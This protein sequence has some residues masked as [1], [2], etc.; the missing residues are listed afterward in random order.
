MTRAMR[1]LAGA[2]CAMA[3]ILPAGAMTTQGWT[4]IELGTL[5]GPGSYGAAIS[6]NGTVVGCADVNGATA[7][8]FI[9]RDGVMRDLTTAS[10]GTS[11]ALAVNDAGAAAGRSE[12]GELVMWSAAGL[13]HFGV[14]GNVG[15]M[16]DAG[17]VVG[18]AG[19]GATSHAF[20]FANGNLVPIAGDGS[21][22][23]AI[24]AEGEIAGT[25][26]SRAFR[27]KD[28]TVTPLGTLGGN[29]SQAKGI[30]DRGAMVG[31]AT[32]ANGQPL[33]FLYDQSMSA[34]PAPGYSSAIAINNRGQVVGSAEGIYGFLV[35]GGSVVRLDA[36]PG[37]AMRGWRHLE[38]TGI[39]DRGWIVGTGTAPDG[40]LRA[41]VLV[42]GTEEVAA[43]LASD[44]RRG[45]RPGY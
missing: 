18:T 44:A 28:G 35:D 22:A 29:R 9:W 3:G 13:I 8:A 37:V 4:L 1:C 2:I 17:T 12:T 40:N 11:C 20:M 43:K 36:L 38:P 25:A 30:N 42:P 32:D 24:N 33:S 27:Y 45:A 14:T 26:Q 15:A 21:E 23:T 41:F 34:L 6:G 5:G 16:N 39:N 19:Q 7:H 10:S 31:M